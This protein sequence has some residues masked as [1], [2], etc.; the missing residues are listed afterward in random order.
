MKSEKLIPE[1]QMMKR[2]VVKTLWMEVVGC[3][4][5]RSLLGSHRL[6]LRHR[7]RK[8]MAFSL[9]K[10]ESGSRPGIDRGLSR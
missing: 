10:L 1:F 5:A 3:S 9:A 6:L 4:F 7:H 8:K 2:A